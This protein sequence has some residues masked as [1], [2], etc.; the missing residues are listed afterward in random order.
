MT[1]ALALL[2]TSVFIASETGRTLDT[3]RFPAEIAVSVITIAELLAGVHAA[4][5]TETRARRLT[6]LDSL[7]T[8]TPLPVDETAARE[9]ARMRFRLAEKQRR[10]NINDLWIAAIALAHGLPIVTQDRDYD[11]LEGLGGPEVIAV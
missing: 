11:I 1:A 3:S 7:S 4:L 6:T 9:W 8:L 5:V 10:M 2:D